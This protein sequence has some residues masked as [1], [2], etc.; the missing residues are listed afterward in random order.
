M[1][2]LEIERRVMEV[3]GVRIV[4][5]ADKNAQLGDYTFHNKATGSHTA[6]EWLEKRM[7]GIL[8]GYDVVVLDGNAKSDFHANKTMDSLR[9]TYAKQNA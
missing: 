7:R 2:P 3:E 1:T 9:Y 8:Q 5:R 4:I 6:A